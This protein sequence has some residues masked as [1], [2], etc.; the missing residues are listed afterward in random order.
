MPSI[1][2]AVEFQA[3]V[4]RAFRVDR[5]LK[6]CY[7]NSTMGDGSGPNNQD[8]DRKQQMKT[9]TETVNKT[10][11]GGL[12]VAGKPVKEVGKPSIPPTAEQALEVVT[13]QE[14][15]VK[16]L[17]GEI[18]EATVK[19]GE[20]YLSL[21]KYIRKEQV[22]KANATKWLLDMGFHKVRASEICRV[23]MADDKT[24]SDFEARSI[25]WRGV[26]QITRGNMAE[27]KQV[28]PS[29]LP[30][31]IEKAATAELVKAEEENTAEDKYAGMSEEETIKA[32][33]KDKRDAWRKAIDVKATGVLRC[34]NLLGKKKGKWISP[35]GYELTL[36]W[37]K[38]QVEISAESA[39]K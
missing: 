2:Q 9:K 31:E 19:V 4:Y 23:A 39:E 30:P 11:V 5:Y 10:S 17:A 28:N 33:A 37:S 6:M 29:I 12:E 27:M 20:K 34:A 7:D 15:E 25:G 16:R 36:R 13:K 38:P 26:L 35:E 14:L 18:I 22:V 1:E 32:K 8:P 21:C 3:R 24:W